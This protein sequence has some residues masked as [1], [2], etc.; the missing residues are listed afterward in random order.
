[1]QLDASLPLPFAAR[2]DRILVDAPCSGTGTL[3]RNPEIKWRLGPDDIARLS[4]IQARILDAALAALAPGGR[5]VYA[6]CSLE[7]EE[8]EVVVERALSKTRGLRRLGRSEL[9][10]EFTT[11]AALFDE[12]GYFRTR[13]DLHGTDGFFAAVVLREA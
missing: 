11:L 12:S 13:P 5:L 7:P 8:N 2:F 10:E 1:V 6:T 4:G 3:A 9:V